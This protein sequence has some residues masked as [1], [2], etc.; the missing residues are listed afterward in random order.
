MPAIREVSPEIP[1]TTP[2]K[3]AR[4]TAPYPSTNAELRRHAKRTMTRNLDRDLGDR[5]N[6]IDISDDSDNED[7]TATYIAQPADD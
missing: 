2:C 4:R 6:L 7:Y 1:D 3:V 5:T